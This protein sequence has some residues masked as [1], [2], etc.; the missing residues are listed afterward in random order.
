MPVA[1]FAVR[2]ASV[3]TPGQ[4]DDSQQLAVLSKPHKLGWLLLMRLGRRARRVP[5]ARRLRRE[6]ERS[7]AI[8]VVWR[9]VEAG[10]RQHSRTADAIPATGFE[11]VNFEQRQLSPIP[12]TACGQ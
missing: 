7:M 3:P 2:L 4:P 10:C 6:P 8:D 5:M 12:P 1:S 11:L 9:Q